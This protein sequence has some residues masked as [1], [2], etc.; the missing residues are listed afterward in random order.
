[1]KLEYEANYRMRTN[2]FTCYDKLSPTSILDTFQDVA[3]THAAILKMGFDDMVAKGYYWVV[4][5]EK[6]T[7]LGNV[8]PGET[9][10]AI[11]WPEPKK[12]VSFI[13]NYKMLNE[14]NEVVAVGSSLWVVISSVT[15]RLDRARDVIYDGEYVEEKV[16]DSLDKLKEIEIN[17]D[18]ILHEVKF[19]D[20]DHNKHMN[21]SK[22]MD[23][24]L[25]ILDLKPTEIIK[26]FQLDF[27]HEAKYKDVIK[28]KY[29]K[30]DN[31]YYF[32]GY[33]KDVLAIRAEIEV[34]NA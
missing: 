28:L 30:I 20:L 17:S 26:S 34:S 25:D 18:F 33:I 21:N 7:I 5:R 8:K 31:I 9:I 6:V 14:S 22:Y 12:G 27:L 24:F 16:Y 3:G 29:Q 1:M 23:V 13:R 19:R 32:V 15:R 4:F 10:K 11:T 2:D